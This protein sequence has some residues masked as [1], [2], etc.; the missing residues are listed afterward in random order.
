M[1]DGQ[2]VPDQDLAAWYRERML[3]DWQGQPF[4]IHRYIDGRVL[5]AYVGRDFAWAEKSDLEGNLYDGWLCD[6]PEWEIEN[7][8]IERT[9]LLEWE[10]YRRTFKVEPPDDLFCE[11]RPA[12]DQE[13]IKEDAA[14]HDRLRSSAHSDADSPM[15]TYDRG[16]VKAGNRYAP[17]PSQIPTFLAPTTSGPGT[18]TSS[19]PTDREESS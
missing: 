7:V 3:F 10:R 6:L 13:W 9:D 17:Y 11:V 5:G 1:I 18:S 15:G 8:R 14:G 16:T 2:R 4:H 12:S 19:D